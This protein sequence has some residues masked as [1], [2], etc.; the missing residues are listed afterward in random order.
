MVSDH[1]GIAGLSEPTL[2]KLANEVVALDYENVS[3]LAGALHPFDS[4]ACS[5]RECG[6]FD[7]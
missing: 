4:T 7:A 6:D 5:P 1:H 3:S 2:E